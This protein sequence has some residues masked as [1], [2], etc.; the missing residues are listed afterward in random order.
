[1]TGWSGL[2]EHRRGQA[3]VALAAVFWSSAGILQRELSMNIQTQLAGR[4]LFASLA[5]GAYAVRSE[6]GRP[7]W[8]VFRSMGGAGLAVAAST[9]VASGSFIYAINHTT[10]AHVLFMQ[11]ASPIVAALLAWSVLGERASRRTVAAMIVALVGVGVMIGDPRGG[12][13]LGDVS[14][15]VMAFSFAIAIV[16]TRHRREV[17]M[18]PAMCLAQVMILVTFAPLCSP[19]QVGPRD[20]L[21]LVAMGVGQMGFAMALFTVGARLIPA[22]EAALLTLLEVVL[23]PLWVWVGVGERPNT[24]TLIGGAI[25]VGAVMLQARG[26]RAP[27]EVPAAERAAA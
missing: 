7:A 25:V 19:G 22:A 23:G 12:A 13:W 26:D 9:A 18:A 4:A 5:L 6:A 14:S 3:A 21:L 17:S 16:I 10:V 27:M 24:A 8:A 2:D 11:A 20:G 1:M 15:L